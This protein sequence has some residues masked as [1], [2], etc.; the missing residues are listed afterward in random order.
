MNNKQ[1][2]AVQWLIEQINS[3]CTNSTFVRP[4]LIEKAVEMEREQIIDAFGYGHNEGCSYMYGGNSA[5]PIT[6]EQYFTD[7]YQTNER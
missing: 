4:E 2:T 6:A 7:S 3:D 5:D 1:Q